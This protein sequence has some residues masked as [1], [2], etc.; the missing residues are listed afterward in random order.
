MGQHEDE[1]AEER[2]YAP[3]RWI[4]RE[5]LDRRYPSVQPMEGEE[6]DEIVFTDP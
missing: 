4:T 1:R 3:A 6:S 2:F 5:E